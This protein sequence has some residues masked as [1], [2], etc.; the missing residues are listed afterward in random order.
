[1][2]LIGLFNELKKRNISLWWEDGRLK[3]FLPKDAR[4]T[5]AEQAFVGVSKPAIL[6]ALFRN[7]VRSK[8]DFGARTIFRL[9]G[10]PGRGVPS[11]AQE[12]LWFIERLDPGSRAYHVPLAFDLGAAA[13]LEAF[14][15]SFRGVVERHEVLRTVIR[16]D[17]EGNAFTEVLPPPPDIREE[18]TDAAEVPGKLREAIL[19]PFDLSGEAP[20]RALVLTTGEGAVALV[21]FHHIA[22]DGWSTEIFV[23]ELERGYRACIEGRESGLAASDI[24]YGDFAAWQRE[25]LSG[26]ELAAQIDYWRG[27]LP[28]PE[29]LAFPTD[30]PRPARPD[31]RG[32]DVRF[33]VDRDVSE[34]LRHLAS[35]LGVTLFPVLLSAFHILLHQYTGQGALVVGT[36]S[37]NRNHRQLEG[38]V[39]YFVNSLPLRAEIDP[40]QSFAALVRQV[41][42]N[43]LGAQRHQDLPFEK[44]V[45]ALKPEPDPSRHPLFQVMFGLQGFDTG[46]ERVLKPIPLD[47]HYTPA[48]FDLSL[49]LREGGQALEGTFNYAVALFDR[50]TAERVKDHYLR[51]LDQVSTDPRVPLR[52]VSLL[53]EEEYRRIVFDWS[54]ARE[55]FDTG[56]T[57]VERFEDQ[58][59]RTPLETAVIGRDERVS[60][61]ELNARA[62]RLAHTLRRDYRACTGTDIAAD[63]LIGIYLERSLAMLVGILGILKAGAAYVPLDLADPEDRLRFKILDCGCRL[64][65]TSSACL[66]DLVFLTE[67]DAVPLSL[68]GYA[69]EIGRAPSDNPRRVNTPADLAYVIYT[70][71][72]TGRPKG[73]MLEHRSVVNYAENVRRA[74]RPGKKIVDLSSSLSFDLTVTTTLVPLLHGDTIAVY[75]GNLRDIGDFTRH[76]ACHGVTFVKTV[77]SLLYLLLQ[78]P[79]PPSLSEVFVGGEK[80]NRDLLPD[81]PGL[82]VYDEY[83]PT[84]T[85]VGATL[86]VVRPANQPGIGKPYRNYRVYL[87][88]PAG[89]PVP[90]GAVGEMHIGGDG[91]ARGYLHRP[92]L[93]AERFLENPFATPEELEQGRNTRYYRTG[94]LARWRGDGNL[95][96]LGRNDDQVKV[97]G[98]RVELGEIEDKLSAHPAISQCTVLCRERGGNAYLA[99]W[100]LSAEELPGEALREYLSALLPDYMVP[101]FFVRLEEMPLTPN[102]KVDRKALPEPAFQGDDDRYA[103]P[104]DEVEGALCRIWREVLGLER[105][106]VTDDFFR[107]GGNSILAIRLAHRMSK[108]LE[109]D[110][111]VSAVFERKTVRG[112]S[113]ALPRFRRQVTI[114]PCP[115]GDAVLSFAQ[116]RLYFIEQY[117]GGCDAYHIPMLFE[118]PGTTDVEALSRAIRDIVRRHGVLRTVFVRDER[119]GVLQRTLEDPVEI[120]EEDLGGT[121]VLARAA[122]EIRSVFDLHR[123]YPLRVRLYRAGPKRFLLVTLHHIAF[124]GWSTDVFLDELNRLYR[125]HRDGSA[126][127]LPEPPIQYRDF[128]AWQRGYLS[129][130]RLDAE[131]AYWKQALE[132]CETLELP[133]DRPRPAEFRYEGDYVLFTLDR[134][135]SSGLRETVKRFGTSPYTVFLSAFF[136]LL[137]KY[138][139]QGDFVI[140]T[141]TANR[142]YPQLEGLIGFFVNTTVTRCRLAPDLDLGT[143]VRRVADAQAA[144]QDHQDLPF[145][146]LVDLLQVEKDPSRH[147]LIQ[148]MFS[149]QSFGKAGDGER[150]FLRPVDVSP[151]YRVSKFDLGLFVDDARECVQFG[152]NYAVSLFDRST[153]ERMAGHYLNVLRAL[154]S[155]G[156]PRVRDVGL[157]SAAER[158]TV[159]YAWN[160]TRFDY[161]REKTLVEVFEEQVRLAPEATAL[162]YEGE[163]LSYRQLNERA[164]RLARALRRDHREC[165]G[166][167]IAGDTLVGLY[168]ER[169]VDLVAGILGILK[170]GAAYVPFDRA[171]PPER[172]RFKVKDCGCRLVVTSSACLAE[173]VSLADLDVTPVALDAYR[174]EI[175]SFAGDDPPHVNGPRDLAYV[176][177]TSGSTG[178]PKGVLLEH[179]GVVN[180]VMSHRRSFGLGAG[181]RVLQFAPVSFDASVSTLFCALL[182][183]ASL[184][185]CTEE[186]RKDARALAAYLAAER[187]TLADLPAKLLELLPRDVP[188]P[189]LRHVITA[190][191][192]CNAKTMDHWGGRVALL[193]AYGPTEATVCATFARHA[194]GDRNTDIGRPIGNKR[195]Y[196]LDPGL[197]PVPPGVPGELYIGGDG[198]AR[199]YHNRPELTAARFPDDPFRVETGRPDVE[200]RMYRTG[201][202]VRWT[203]RGTLEFIGRNDD[204]VKVHGYRIELGEVEQKLSALEP[205]TLCAVKVIERDGRRHLCAWYAASRPFP[206]AEAREGLAA[207]LPD[208]MVPSFFVEMD[209]FPLN[210]SGKIDRGALPDPATAAAPGSCDAPRDALQEQLCAIFR[211]LLGLECVGTRDDFFRIGGDSIL[212]IQLSS[213]L[214]DAELE[215]SVKD[216]FRNP[217]VEKLAQFLGAGRSAATPVVAEQGPLD[218]EFGLLPIQRWFFRQAESGEIPRRHH[219]NQCF[220][221]RTPELEPA[222][223]TR[224][225]GALAAQHDMLR[226]TFSGDRQ[227]YHR[228]MPLPELKVLDR[229]GL[230]DV[231][232]QEVLT[233]WQS[234]FD[235]ERGPLW[236]C[237]YVHGYDDGSARL[238]FAFHHLVVDAVSWRILVEDLQRLVR[239]EAL[240]EKTSSY[241]QWVRV[242]E[243]YPDGHPDER[244]YWEQVLASLPD[245]RRTLND[246]GPPLDREVRLERDETHRLIHEAPGAYGAG[247]NDLLLT[248]LALA[249]REWH[250]GDRQGV[251]LEGH[252][253]EPID[254]AIDHSHTV[255]WFTTR[256][257]MALP[258]RETVGRSLAEIQRTLRQ[259]PCKGLGW[260]AFSEAARDASDTRLADAGLPPVTFNYL[261]QLESGAGEAF[262]Q[263]TAEPPGRGSAPENRDDSRIAVNGF[264]AEGA[265]RFHVAARLEAADADR[266]A[267]AFGNALRDII[268]HIPETASRGTHPDLDAPEFEY[269]PTLALN[270]D[271]DTDRVMIVIHPDSGYEAYMATLYPAL[272][273]DVHV[274]L[275]D[276]FYRKRYLRD[277]V[278]A[279]Q[280]PLHGFGDLADHYVRVLTTEHGALLSRSECGVAGYSFGGPIALEVAARLKSR[281]I[282]VRRLYLVDPLIP[283]LLR[284]HRDLPCSEWYEGYSPGPATVPVTHF[285]CTVPDPTL[286]GY[287]EYFTDPAGYSLRPIADD[288][289]EVP[290]ECPHLDILRHAPF[291][292]AFGDRAR[293]DFGT[294]P[295]APRAPVAPSLPG[296]DLERQVRDIART[297]LEAGDGVGID[298][299]ESLFLQGCTSL[300]TL[301]LLALVN[302]KFGLDLS[303]ADVATRF[304]V[305]GLAEAVRDARAGEPPGDAWK[306]VE[307]EPRAPGAPNLYVFPGLIGSVGSY[308]TLCLRLSERFRVVF[309]EPKGM[310]GTMVPFASREEAL[311][312]YVGEITRRDAPGSPLY[313]AGHSVGA[314]LSL[315]VALRLEDLGYAHV[316]LINID[317]YL[318]KIHSV[319]ES[320]GTEDM[321]AALVDVVRVFFAPGAEAT[322]ADREQDPLRRIAA[323]LFPR[324]DVSRDHALR[325]ALGYRNIW[326]QQLGEML[327]YEEPPRKFGGAALLC[328]ARGTREE[329]ARITLQ[330]CQD[331]YARDVTVTGVPGDHLSCITDRGHV[332]ALCSAVFAWAE[333]GACP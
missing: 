312:R 38:L 103:A 328:A 107:L 305:A 172:L 317:G 191:E 326:R 183:G 114:P 77:P 248:A 239:G 219:W 127:D 113:E 211:Q 122:D 15:R 182:T 322:P 124:D 17:P 244:A 220:L 149:L 92:E 280:V 332:E 34:R 206:P 144:V 333:T 212:S 153:V 110:I 203:P 218:G 282:R 296:D 302:Q 288:L 316:N 254:P 207:L 243:G 94:D 329:V 123:E 24:Q 289:E 293:A 313:L 86:S 85:T 234:T 277:G 297:V 225:L 104:R 90:V 140:G 253:R 22:F 304:S 257:P 117:E 299:S 102:G 52:Q 81:L 320:L 51:V 45:E 295:P 300:R 260:G 93:T 28:S 213:A 156:N 96:Y 138:G 159:L 116:E 54:G 20:V 79:P 283:G 321:D 25:F 72:S 240:R 130:E 331:R 128:A 274:I 133:L 325:V 262:W 121:D 6:D 241:R 327:A 160:E 284:A 2:T 78:Q 256:Y 310:Y 222:V 180:L 176:I 181:A 74:T 129:G 179:Y 118:V 311:T 255:G 197:N 276:N 59:E 56:K 115:P 68:D 41:Q 163:R 32:D 30:R 235:L 31:Y 290:V 307:F 205:V 61:R 83:G 26:E 231:D 167:E 136:L 194:P 237:G 166:G 108:E 143:L 265:L 165:L 65:L 188:L 238:H 48:K 168:L 148:V 152:F 315:D 251:T 135:L 301:S 224:A 216:I 109:R 187:I 264:V 217:T 82:S 60:Y 200:R 306:P 291:L 286:P 173:L 281:G 12:S 95:E 189:D 84:E 88:D 67:T 270:A 50:A 169:S 100:Y 29:P 314:V 158:D 19:A 177:Y 4:L 192:V 36:P 11:F 126:L 141:P 97:R 154:A 195:V 298:R 196:V 161:P 266:F 111:P 18:R 75:P 132:G 230:S 91:L 267:E 193:N 223:V 269:I 120:R 1:M 89:R 232:L 233:G 55:D 226:A 198:L 139:G 278:V 70:S 227:R 105:V 80:L 228:D 319:T 272:P 261:G 208:Y 101:S 37:A 171:D 44:I 210:A 73:A 27:A 14:R 145:E 64:V 309:L 35:D 229:R 215:C 63:T 146:K 76:L 190:G 273:R 268:R 174:D 151:A 33:A 157:L 287:A 247:I 39:G 330:S 66:R 186:T 170:S 43:L 175:A 285:R 271:A 249:L 112:L 245:Y 131:L 98:F 58:V 292:R 137:H 214:R 221:V 57:L 9:A 324:G 23:R 250:G 258:L 294:L 87:L 199:G 202:L 49:F 47:G 150:P 323:M 16:Q 246:P 134:E 10:D 201:D 155:G 275:V 7:G 308:S 3:A 119:G 46:G 184:H 147:P 178:T 162:V 71:G 318:H 303:L 99:A 142:L 106:G 204:Q 5:D 252:G 263:L 125:H 53:G 236:H 62:N 242:V 42:A 209:R 259:V 69:A 13:D 40:G 279:G 21:V 8:E 185:L 164:N